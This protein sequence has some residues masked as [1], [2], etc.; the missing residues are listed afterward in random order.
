MTAAPSHKLKSFSCQLNTF[1]VFIPALFTKLNTSLDESVLRKIKKKYKMEYYVVLLEQNIL[2]AVK[3]QWIENSNSV[4][5]V[6]VF[7]SSDRNAVPNFE[8]NK[9]YYF[10]E[11]QTACYNCRIVQKFGSYIHF[12]YRFIFYFEIHFY[13]YFNVY[14]S[15]S[16]TIEAA[17]EYV[18]IRQRRPLRTITLNENPSRNT[19]LKSKE[20]KN[21]EVVEYHVIDDDP[22]EYSNAQNQPAVVSNNVDGQNQ[23]RIASILFRVCLIYIFTFQFHMTFIHFNF[24]MFIEFE[25]SLVQ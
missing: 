17:E 12:L 2:I 4:E 10:K 24:H 25:F 6:A 20:R 7:Y 11:N 18:S 15:F 8:R 3:K 5:Q 16:E 23:I 22:D 9:M 19:I 21:R 1:I 13:L 14:F